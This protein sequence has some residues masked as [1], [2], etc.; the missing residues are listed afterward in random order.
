MPEQDFQ[1]VNT[2]VFPSTARRGRSCGELKIQG[3]KASALAA[4]YGT[5]L[6]VVDEA[7]VRARAQRTRL[8]FES[9][10]AKIGTTVQIFYAGK[11]L[12]NVEVARWVSEEGLGVDVAS[13][14]ELGV[15]LAAGVNPE[16]IGVHGNNKSLAEIELAVQAGAHAIVIDSEQEIERVAAVAERIGVRQAVR[17]RINS[18]VHA[19][20]HEF[21]ATSHEDQKFGLPLAEAVRAARMIRNH[22]SLEFLG[23]HG[24]IGS[25]IFAPGGFKEAA[26]KLLS[27]YGELRESGPVPELNLGGGFGINYQDSDDAPEIELLAHEIMQAVSEACER[28]QIEV[29]RLAFEPGRSITGPA[30]VTLYTVGTTKPVALTE[31]NPADAGFEERLYVSVDGGMSDNV[32][33]ALYGAEYEVRLANRRSNA[34]K[35]LVRVVGKHCEAGDIIVDHAFLPADIRPGDTLA[36]AATGAYCWSL[37]SNYNY[38]PRPPMVAVK[39]GKS[40]LIV[41]GQSEAD[42]IA[43]SVTGAEETTH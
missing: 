23:L 37:S 24:H 29:P 27:V 12:L 36:V 8:A 25:Q 35:A 32:R 6:Y 33:P 16:M 21:L 9:E 10:A 42:L 31:Q 13:G 26:Q 11:A 2:R 18:G 1:S 19:G 15:A 28:Y 14:G 40:R 7:E 43:Q 17:L 5:P 39:D 34:G 41:R 22:K 3:I 38:L 30:G 4:T 20:A